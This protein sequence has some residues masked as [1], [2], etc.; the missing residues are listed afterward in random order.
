MSTRLRDAVTLTAAG[1]RLDGGAHWPLPRP[2]GSAPTTMGAIGGPGGYVAPVAP[3][4]VGSGP[5]PAADTGAC[6]RGYRVGYAQSG[7]AALGRDLSPLNVYATPGVSMTPTTA[8]QVHAALAAL[9]AHEIVWHTINGI[10]RADLLR[11]S[12]T[13]RGRGG[14]RGRQGGASV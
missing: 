11:C 4:S 8:R 2:P 12:Q 14:K 3:V 5:D 10:A 13:G 7:D 1:A 9:R 6:V